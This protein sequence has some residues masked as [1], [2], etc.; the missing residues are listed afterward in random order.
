VGTFAASGNAALADSLAVEWLY[1][2]GMVALKYRSGGSHSPERWL[3]MVRIIH[4]FN[5]NIFLTS[6][7]AAFSVALHYQNHEMSTMKKA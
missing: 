7:Q 3:K 2:S 1:P 5:F 4:I 6:N